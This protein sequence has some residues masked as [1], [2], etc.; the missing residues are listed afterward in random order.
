[1]LLGVDGLRRPSDVV[2]LDIRA[3]TG[4]H[5]AALGRSLGYLNFS[6]F[7]INELQVQLLAV[8]CDPVKA[9]TPRRKNKKTDEGQRLR[10]D[11]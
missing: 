8:L 10:L 5:L 4:S 6:M 1:M 2:G 11:G 3:F 7:V 9:L